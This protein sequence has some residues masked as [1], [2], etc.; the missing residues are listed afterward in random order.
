MGSRRGKGESMKR[1]IVHVTNFLSG[2]S[3]LKINFASRR[4]FCFGSAALACIAVLNPMGSVSLF[5]PAKLNLFLAVTG[6]R[7]DGYHD[8]L[9]V[10]APVDFGDRLKIETRTGGEFSLECDEPAVPRDESNLV[11]KAA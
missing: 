11:L 5:S 9:S 1:E 8:L 6:R 2:I 4:F 3:A 7:P 10:A